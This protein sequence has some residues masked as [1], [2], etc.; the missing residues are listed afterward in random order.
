M[1]PDDM[2]ERLLDFGARVG[3]VVDAL[4]NRRLGRHVA[5]QL[6]RCGTS[7]MS[8]YE[9]ACAAESRADFIHKVRICLKETRETRNWL[10]FIIRAKLLPA[11]RLTVLLD[12]ANQLCNIFGQSV[13]TATKNKGRQR[14]SANSK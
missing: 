5:S 3:L 9:E 8:N 6:V 13:V 11:K 14:P 7:P 4:P 2:V 12:E 1:N 10:R